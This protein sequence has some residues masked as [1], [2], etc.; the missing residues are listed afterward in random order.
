VAT[1]QEKIII[2]AATATVMIHTAEAVNTE[3]EAG[4]A[5]RKTNM[6]EAVEEDPAILIPTAAVKDIQ[7]II[8]AEWMRIIIQEETAMMM[9][10]PAQ[11]GIAE[12][13]NFFLPLTY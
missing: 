13:D 11:A 12:T 10:I 8:A 1:A 5:D 4:I 3:A 6:A 7:I 2:Q 9:I